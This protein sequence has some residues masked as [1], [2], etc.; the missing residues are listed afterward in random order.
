M[1]TLSNNA[2]GLAL[3]LQVEEIYGKV[4]TSDSLLETVLCWGINCNSGLSGKSRD[5]PK[6][7]ILNKQIKHS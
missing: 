6:N 4:Y 2:K 3:P 7:R 5:P 1:I